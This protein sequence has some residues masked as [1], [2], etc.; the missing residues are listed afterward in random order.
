M[1]FNIVPTLV[2][3]TLAVLFAGSAHAVQITV[4]DPLVTTTSVTGA[5]VETFNSG[6]CG[7]YFSCTGNFQIVTGSVSSQY[8]QP[9]NTGSDYLSVPRDGSSG[10]ASLMLGTTA[11]YFGLYWGSIDTYNT[12]SFLLNGDEVESFTGTDIVA[13]IPG[14]ANGNQSADTSNRYFNFFFGNQLFNEVELISTGRAFETD[15]HAFATV[16]EPGTLALLALGLTGLLIA[17]RRK[18][19]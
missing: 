12:L 5:S 8:A 14:T 3:T 1:K 19:A 16:P 17:R 11:N 6:T 13:Y 4:E 15:N 2:A 18:Q 10:T 7:T 9:A